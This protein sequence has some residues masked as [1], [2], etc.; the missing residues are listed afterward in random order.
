MKIL[1]FGSLNI[2]YVYSVDH[3]VRP[4]ET[5]ASN[6]LEIFPGGKGLNQSIALAKAGADV[7]HAGIIG[8][9]GIMLSETLVAQGVRVE[10][11]KE[12]NDQ[13]GHAIIQVDQEGSNNILLYG[14]ANK[15]VDRT[16]IDEVLSH[17]SDEDIILLQNEI[18]EVGY[19]IEK[20]YRKGMK[21]AF[22]PSPIDQAITELPLEKVDWFILNEIEGMCLTGSEDKSGIADKLLS[23][24]PDA[25]IIL[26]L[27]SE[28]VLYKDK[29]K[30]YEQ[31]IY[32]VK[33]ID[34]TAAGD[35]FTGY[36]LASIVEGLSVPKSL[37]RASKAAA[38]AV[39][40]KGAATSIPTAKE[41][42][43]STIKIV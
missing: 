26:T 43:E 39:S 16:F 42:E 17:F 18:S 4:G 10:Y 27:G 32:S 31:S 15:A 13:T 11:L 6:N 28:G 12:C 29:L 23:K 41:V 3:F 5:L 36:Y 35:T 37:D 25:H 8:K 14:G 19:I 2:D 34:T 24:Y 1:N 40:R 30:E 9:D 7:Y 21:I 20:A 33:A 38:I 22:N